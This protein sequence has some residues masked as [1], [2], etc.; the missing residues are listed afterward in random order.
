MGPSDIACGVA[1]HE[2]CYITENQSDVGSND[3]SSPT[4]PWFCE[5]CLYGLTKPPYCELCPN[6]FGAFKR[7]GIVHFGRYGNIGGGW[8][9]LLCA[10]YTPGMTFGD[11]AHLTAVSWQELDYRLFGKRVCSG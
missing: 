10:L 7:A 2:D 5:P 8:V 11:V 1:V 6:R 9:H 3:S 4:E